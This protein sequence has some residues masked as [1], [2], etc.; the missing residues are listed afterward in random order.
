MPI[1]LIALI[2]SA[3]Q[4]MPPLA[5]PVCQNARPGVAA[6]DSLYRSGSARA[7]RL[8]ELPPA[9]HI[10]TVLR[11]EDGCERPVIVRYGIGGDPIRRR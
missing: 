4:A 11:R 9:D 6:S 5:V 7:Q 8:G 2:S 10:L 3:A 1:A